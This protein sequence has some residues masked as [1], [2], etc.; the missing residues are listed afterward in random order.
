MSASP[1]IAVPQSMKHRP[2]LRNF[3]ANS[4]VCFTKIVSQEF[5]SRRKFFLQALPVTPYLRC[6]QCR[7]L[8]PRP[9]PSP[10]GL[11]ALTSSRMRRTQSVTTSTSRGGRGKNC[12]H[13]SGTGGSQVRSQTIFQSFHSI[14][15]TASDVFNF[16]MS[17]N[18]SGISSFLRLACVC[19]AVASR[20]SKEQ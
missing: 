19:S 7:Q 13:R 8:L 16:F 9:A 3:P 4:R 17:R 1:T 2:N 18:Y 14:G 10:L 6:G 5:H 20:T 15:H 11:T 12:P